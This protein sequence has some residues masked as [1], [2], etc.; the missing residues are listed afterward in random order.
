ADAV[1]RHLG[2]GASDVWVR[3]L[4]SFH[5]GG[6]G[7]SAR[8]Y[9]AGNEV[10][11]GAG[12]WDCADYARRCAEHGATL[13]S[14][15]PSQVVDLVDAGLEAPPSLRAVLV[16]GGALPENVREAGVGLGWPLLPSY[17]LTEAGSQVATARAD[18]AGTGGSELLVLEHWRAR[19]TGGGLLEIAGPALFT[20]YLELDPANGM[21]RL[22]RKEGEYFTTGDRVRLDS[23]ENGTALCWLERESGVVKILGE[24]VALSG[25]EKRIAGVAA[26][27]GI[28]AGEMVL[29]PIADRRRGWR[30]V[31][32]VSGKIEQEAVLGILAAVNQGVPAFE[33][34]EGPARVAEIPRS[35]IGKVDR[36]S[37][38]QMLGP[39]EPGNMG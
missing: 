11:D 15:V 2:V 17:G 35:A 18:T 21:V 29:L 31:L 19:L 22:E 10:I 7:I 1:N 12:R 8:A 37:L 36:G 28:P 24:L 9:R 38:E 20:G 33:R 34:L 32:V 23:H 6:F 14:L 13:S 4:P 27:L 5:V 25:V 30:L 16:G 39:Y 26:E 3:V